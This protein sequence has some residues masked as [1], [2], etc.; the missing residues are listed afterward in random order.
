VV[1][2][3]IA[4]G[5]TTSEQLLAYDDPA[6]MAAHALREAL[7]RRGVAVGGTAVA[8]HREPGEAP[9]ALAGVE[10]AA[11]E[12][13]PLAQWVQVLNKVSQNLHAEMVLRTVSRARRG[14]GTREDGLEELRTWLTSIGVERGSYDLVDG[15]G[16]SRRNLL[17]PVAT[18]RLLLHMYRSGLRDTWIAAMPIG[19]GDGTLAKRFA[20]MPAGQYVRAKTGTISHVTG[21]SGYLVPEKGPRYVF[22]ILV[23][24]YEAPAKEI[25]DT[26]DKIVLE[27]LRQRR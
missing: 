23:N 27:L 16:L 22:S 15:S 1:R 19:A 24:G 3:A 7:L 11:R 20:G 2:G 10:L 6:L 8:N 12:S 25:R 9:S 14:T 13:A 26:V 5:A 4:I 21:L 17:S 18:V